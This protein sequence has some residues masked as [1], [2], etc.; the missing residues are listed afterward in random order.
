MRDPTVKTYEVEGE[1]TF[2]LEMLSTDRSWPTTHK[3]A[4]LIHD[5]DRRRIGLATMAIYSPSRS[6]WTRLGWKVLD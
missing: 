6:Q 4:Q 1:G 3:D 2:P 5:M